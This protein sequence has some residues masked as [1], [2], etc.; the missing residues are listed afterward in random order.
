MENLWN[1]KPP[2][3]LKG[4]LRQGIQLI[5]GSVLISKETITFKLRRSLIFIERNT[6]I[7]I[8]LRTELNTQF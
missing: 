8:P 6:L 3:P 7:N 1:S 2:V 4:R 5:M